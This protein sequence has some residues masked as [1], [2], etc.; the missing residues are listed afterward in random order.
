MIASLAAIVALAS[1]APAALSP[2]D[3]VTR[4]QTAWEARVVPAYVSFEIPCADTFLD[5]QCAP[6][7]IVNFVVR[8]SDGRTYAESIDLPKRQ[9]MCGGFI[10]GPAS[11]P[12]GFFRRIDANN[13]PSTLATP[14]PPENFAADPFGPK[15]IASVTVT[16]RA[17]TVTLAAL[18]N[19]DGASVYHLRLVPNYTPDALPLRELW[20]DTSTFQVLQLTYARQAESGAA[21]GT[22][23]YRFAQVGPDH[24]WA[25]VYIDATLPVKGSKT[26][27]NPHSDLANVSFPKEQPGWRFRPGCVS[28]S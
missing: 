4:A 6:K 20:I 23:Q 8:M 1:P 10:Y 28:G 3:I 13:V 24:I 15:L 25:I 5:V 14:P 22:V 18:E 7:A 27:A 9:L 19:L 17:Y 26:V 16:D 21:N 2:Y 12:F 11:T